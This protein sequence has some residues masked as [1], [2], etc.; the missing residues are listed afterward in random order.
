MAWLAAG[1]FVVLLTMLAFDRP[2]AIAVARSPASTV[3]MVGLFADYAKGIYFVLLALVATLVSLLAFLAVPEYRSDAALPTTLKAGFVFSTTLLALLLA[4]LLKVL[5]GRARP[6]LLPLAGPFAFSP[7]STAKEMTSFPSA[8]TAMA[9]AF[10]G[11][12]AWAAKAYV[13]RISA[14]VLFVPAVLIAA[15][16]VVVSAH[17]LSDVLAGMVL[18]AALVGWLGQVFQQR[19]K[20]NQERLR[21]L[22]RWIRSVVLPA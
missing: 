22:R 18:S 16:R 13:G 15:S 21:Q 19:Y 7:F 4:T 5:I 11:S 20:V 2:L 1:V 3:E 8:E 6:E 9:V 10:F 12:F 14:I 17:Y